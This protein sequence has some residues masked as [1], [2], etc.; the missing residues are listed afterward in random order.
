MVMNKKGEG[1][2]LG[3]IAGLLI[4]GVFVALVIYFIVGVA[5]KG[6]DLSNIPPSV[7]SGKAEICASLGSKQTAYCEYTEYSENNYINC[8]YEGNADFRAQV[9]NAVSD[10]P[11]CLVTE[12]NFCA[13]LRKDSNFKGAVVNSLKC[14]KYD[15]DFNGKVDEADVEIV[16]KCIG[17]TLTNDECD[18]N[19]DGPIDSLDAQ[20]ITNQL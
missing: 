5:D 4:L 19:L 10:A 3:T 2:P 1:T 13:N 7:L 8:A 17:G 20:L 14:I 6:K 16:N 9:N 12:R 11:K 18:V 15:L